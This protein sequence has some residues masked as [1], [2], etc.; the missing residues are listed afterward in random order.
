MQRL[1]QQALQARANQY[2]YILKQT[3]KPTLKQH[4]NRQ[5]NKV[6]PLTGGEREGHLTTRGEEMSNVKNV[7][8]KNPP[9]NSSNQTRVINQSHTIK[10]PH[11][12]HAIK[13]GTKIMKSNLCHQKYLPNECNQNYTPNSINKN[14]HQ[15]NTIKTHKNCKWQR[16]SK[17]FQIFK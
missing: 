11:Q 9:A 8:C 12:I 7:K 13:P 17:N 2:H 1:F 6:K 15:T 5:Q 14:P 3:P 16:R 10:K 4:T